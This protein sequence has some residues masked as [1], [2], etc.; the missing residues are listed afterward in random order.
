[1]IFINTIQIYT[2]YI[3]VVLK[4][5]VYNNHNLLHTLG[6]KS[7]RKKIYGNFSVKKNMLKNLKKIS[8]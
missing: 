1:M 4:M 5:T 8:F 6:R 3:Y 2:L 7:M